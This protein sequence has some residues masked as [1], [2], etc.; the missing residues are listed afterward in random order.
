MQHLLQH[1]TVSQKFFQLTKKVHGPGIQKHTHLQVSVPIRRTKTKA[2]Q[3]P[4]IEEDNSDSDDDVDVD[5]KIEC[6]SSTCKRSPL[7]ASPTFEVPR[8]D[9]DNIVQIDNY[10]R[11]PGALE[12]LAAAGIIYT[13]PTYKC[14]IGKCEACGVE[15]AF[16]KQRLVPFCLRSFFFLPLSH[17]GR[18]GSPALHLLSTCLGSIPRAVLLLVLYPFGLF[19]EWCCRCASE[20][21]EKK[22]VNIKLIETLE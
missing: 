15:R 21:D 22:R 1:A 17:N 12:W 3:H 10:E 11:I 14:S 20:N 7:R 9:P 13:P 5:T 16:S 2:D 8:D 4:C 18:D 19:N 6:N